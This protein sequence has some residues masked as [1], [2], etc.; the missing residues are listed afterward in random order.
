MSDHDKIIEMPEQEASFP[1]ELEGMQ[2]YLANNTQYPEEAMEKGEQGK[3][4]VEFIVEKDGSVS[5][6]KILRGVSKSIDN[7][8]IRVVSAMPKWEPA[9]HQ[10][11]IVRSR[12]RIPINFTFE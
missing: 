9:V 7:E 11:Q 2:K 6:V 5:H 3:V 8:T 4:F 12:C 1:G 10:K